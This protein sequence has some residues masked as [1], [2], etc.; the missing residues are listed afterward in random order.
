MEQWWRVT[1]LRCIGEP[2]AEPAHL[3]NGRTAVRNAHDRS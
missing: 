1:M 3:L 2:F